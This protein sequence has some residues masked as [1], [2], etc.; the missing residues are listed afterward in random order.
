MDIIYFID[1]IIWLYIGIDDSL[2]VKCNVSVEYFIRDT[3][4]SSGCM[5][6]NGQWTIRKNA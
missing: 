1:F 2:M 5:T 4:I 6:T 3:S